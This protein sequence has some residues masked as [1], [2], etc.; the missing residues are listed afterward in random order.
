LG[1]IQT[2]SKENV[3]TISKDDKRLRNYLVSLRK[4]NHDYND[5]QDLVQKNTT[6]TEA[7][8]RAFKKM[9]LRMMKRYYEEQPDE[10]KR[11][12]KDM[13]EKLTYDLYVKS[14]REYLSQLLPPIFIYSS[15]FYLSRL[16]A[17]HALSR[18][19]EGDFDP[20]GF[21]NRQLPLIREFLFLADMTERTN[22][23]V[24]ELIKFYSQEV[25][26]VAS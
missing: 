6:I 3:V 2:V 7:E 11:V 12:K 21:Y 22:E 25:K 4:L 26:Y 1:F 14:M 13:D 18:Y 23:V 19:P 24:G 10:F 20:L 16:L 5:T 15:F 17:P 8:V 9:L